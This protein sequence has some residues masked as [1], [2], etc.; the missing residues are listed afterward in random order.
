MAQGKAM[1]AASFGIKPCKGR[2]TLQTPNVALSGLGCRRRFFRAL[3]WAIELRRVGAALKH[4]D[5]D[6]DVRIPRS[7]PGECCEK[8][9]LACSFNPYVEA[10]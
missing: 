3:R 10:D 5:S 6:K 8:P 9:T 2:N 4:A 7:G 1:G